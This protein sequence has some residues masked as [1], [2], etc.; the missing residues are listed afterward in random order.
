MPKETN[1][2]TQSPKREELIDQVEHI[3]SG[4]IGGRNR[5]IREIIQD[6]MAELNKP[7]KD[8]E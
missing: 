4:E 7:K 2:N 3:K 6:R 1:P 8:K 5:S